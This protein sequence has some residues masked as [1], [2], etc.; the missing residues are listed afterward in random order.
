MMAGQTGAAG[1]YLQLAST[2]CLTVMSLVAKVCIFVAC[3]SLGIGPTSLLRPKPPLA[4]SPAGLQ[5]AGQQGLPVMEVVLARSIVLLIMSSTMLARQAPQAAWPWRSDR[6]A[7]RCTEGS[8][9]ALQALQA[10]QALTSS[11]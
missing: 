5:V 11:I 9:Q 7:L 8:R 4:H 3:C 1:L 2:L 10:S 6:W